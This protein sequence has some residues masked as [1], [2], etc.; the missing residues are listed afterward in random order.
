MARRRDG[1]RRGWRGAVLAGLLALPIWGAGMPGSLEAAAEEV[2]A[3]TVTGH[4][5]ASGRPDIATLRIGVETRADSAAEA[6]AENS[7]AAGRLIAALRASGVPERLIQTQGFAVHPVY[8]SKSSYGREADGFQ[9]SNN[10]VARIEDLGGL[11]ALLDRVVQDGANRIDQLA[12][13]IAD[14]APLEAEARRAAVA[15]ARLAAETIAEAAGLAL[16]P[17]RE[18]RAGGGGRPMP[19]AAARFAAESSSA[20]P[21]Q[22]GELALQAE[23]TVVWELRAPE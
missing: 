9:V 10:V 16:G 2:A 17:I 6:L 22:G 3:I 14:P 1:R 20:V 19:Q 8:G 7:E 4:G 5:T 12:F 15:E 11:G 13:G 18:I 23:V 21:I